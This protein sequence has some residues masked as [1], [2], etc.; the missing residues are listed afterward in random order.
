MGKTVADSRFTILDRDQNMVKIG[1]KQASLA[2]L[3]PGLI[4]IGGVEDGFAF[5]GKRAIG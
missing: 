4:D 2:E 1:G 5:P 3:N